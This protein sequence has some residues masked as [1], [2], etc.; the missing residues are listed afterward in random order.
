MHDKGF[1]QVFEQLHLQMPNAPRARR[2]VVV[3][4]GFS[5]QFSQQAGKI[6]GGECGVDSQHIG[7]GR[8]IG[9]G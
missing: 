6:L 3:L 8:H 7:R 9:D 2:S 5:A 4:T 1:G